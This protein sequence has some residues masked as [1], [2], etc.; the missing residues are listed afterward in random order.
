MTPKQFKQ[1]VPIAKPINVQERGTYDGKELRPYEGRPNA[2][3]AFKLPSVMGSKRMWR[4]GRTE[5]KKES[6]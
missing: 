5:P 3:D 2:M 1:S 6:E 4:D